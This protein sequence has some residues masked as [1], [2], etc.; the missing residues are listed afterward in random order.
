MPKLSLRSAIAAIKRHHALLV[1]PINNKPLPLSLWSVF[2]SGKK[3]EW[4]WSGVGSELIPTLWHLRT[5]LATSNEVVYAKWYQ[6]RA[7]LFSFEL[8]TNLLSTYSSLPDPLAGA[9]DEAKIIHSI[10]MDDSP[11]PTKELK[12]RVREE[13]ATVTN[14][15]DR[16]MKELW[17]RFLIVGYGEAEEGGFP[18]LA[19]GTTK[20]LFEELWD[21]SL[22][23]TSELRDKNLSMLLDK[24]SLFIKHFVRQSKNS[25]K[26]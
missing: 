23:I 15:F 21:T 18:S 24:E 20:N 4:D 9:S 26:R 25:R 22:T 1:F 3:M 6:G 13:S 12:L 17:K 14:T 10:L 7:T 5:E 8:F 19:V 11:L 16:S 2:H